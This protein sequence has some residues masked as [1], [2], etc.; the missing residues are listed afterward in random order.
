V[1]RPVRAEIGNGSVPGRVGR[2]SQA[3]VITALAVGLAG[4][5]IVYHVQLVSGFDRFPGP[6]GDT[7]L[8][9]FLAEHWYQSLLGRDD[10][11]SPPMFF[12]VKHT[13]GYS[14]AVFGFVPLYAVLRSL[15]M[16]IFS[17]L[18]VVVFAF[19][20]LNYAVCFWFLKR[21]L[22]FGLTASCTGALF[23]AFNS[24]RLA[25][26]DHIQL[27]AL[28][29][30]PLIA[31]AIVYFFR[32]AQQISGGRAFLLLAGASVA[33]DLELLTSFYVGWFFAGWMVVLL[34]LSLAIKRTRAFLLAALRYHARAAA[35]AVAVFVVGL[36]P[37]VIVYLPALR[38]TGWQTYGQFLLYLPEL[39]S[40]LLMNEG[41]PVWG[42]VTRTLLQPGNPDFGRRVGVGVVV[43]LVWIAATFL[44]ART[45]LRYRRRDDVGL[46]QLFLALTVLSV[47]AFVVL[48]LQYHGHSLWRI[49]YEIVPGARATRAV[50][51]WVMVLALPI[52][53]ALA[54]AVDWSA[55]RAA[56]LRPDWPRRAATLGVVA[57]ATFAIVE[58]LVLHPGS[59][60]IRQE[61]TRL[62]S[63]ARRLPAGCSSFYIALSPDVGSP[64]DAFQY[65]HDAMFVAL[66]RH[67]PTLNGRSGKYPPDWRLYDIRLP[68]YERNVSDWISQRAVGNSVCRLEVGD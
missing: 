21:V 57:V 15:G 25:Q 37:F 51:R 52:A 31:G 48:T 54:A 18:A 26:E 27:Q 10:V 40:Y 5:A 23:F 56:S 64:Q 36:V 53:V 14:D 12:P 33:L 67:V 66:L 28:F 6:R 68:D 19:N 65:E 22:R 49:V 50:A 30:L 24:P 38:T 62:E 4:M 2:S 63:L 35:G 47:D 60:S 9:A 58:Q 7:R 20:F 11:L 17:A 46:A 3:T 39:K 8:I 16:G 43:S 42:H 59:F 41:N 1:L 55:A 32:D 61:T 29:F 34:I 13:L 45:L 44:A